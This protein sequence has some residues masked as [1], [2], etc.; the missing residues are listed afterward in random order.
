MPFPIFKLPVKFV[1][2]GPSNAGKTFWVDKFLKWQNVVV[3]PP[4]TAVGEPIFKHIFVVYKTWQPIYAE[5]KKKYA[6]TFFTALPSNLEQIL[7][8]STTAHKL[9]FFDDALFEQDLRIADLFVRL[10]RHTQTSLILVTQ[11]IF[12]RSN[13]ILRTVTL[14]ATGLV[15]FRSLRDLS[16]FRYLA[17]QITGGSGNGGKAKNLM[18]AFLDATTGQEFGY[19]FINLD[20]RMPPELQFMANIFNYSPI[21]YKI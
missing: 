3:Q 14:N 5:W 20:P 4:T 16:Q 11:N 18:D 8:T 1:I 6:A 12:E 19:L 7:S 10:G 15:L 9:F 13:K 2:A 17:V 21:V